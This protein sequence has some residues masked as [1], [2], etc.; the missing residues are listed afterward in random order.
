M[1][2]LPYFCAPTCIRCPRTRASLTAPLAKHERVPSQPQRLGYRA[3]PV[4]VPVVTP[5]ILKTPAE[6]A[7]ED[8]PGDKR[9]VAYIVPAADDDV[10]S[11]VLREYVRARLPDYMVPSAFVTL[12]GLPLTPNGKVDPNRLPVPNLTPATP[13]RAPRSVREQV[14]CELFAEVL[15][16]DRVGIDDDF[17]ALGGDS[18]VSI[19]M[20]SRARRAG[21]VISPRDVFEHK[22]VARLA[23]AAREVP[24]AMPE[25][26]DADAGVIPLTPIMRWLC[27][28]DAPIDSFAMGMVVQT[29]AGLS[30]NGLAGL[31]QALVDRHDLLRARLEGDGAGWALRVALVG[32]VAVSERIVRVDAAG[33]D[34]HN[35]P[36][37]IQTEAAT[38][39]AGLDPQDGVM[40]QAVWLDRGSARPG[41][42]LLVIH[43]LAV[44][45][46]SWRILL[47][48]LA[49][50]GAQLAAGQTPLL[51]PCGT[52]F[53]RWACL[54]AAQAQDPARVGELATWTAMLDGVDPLLGA[55]A[56]NPATDTSGGCREL[57]LASPT[58]TKP[59]LTSTPAAFNAG[60][61]D[62][63]LC[64]LALAVTSWR[65]HCR[66]DDGT[67]CVLVDLEGHGHQG[68]WSPVWTCPAPSAG[69]PSPSRCVWISAGSTWTRRWPVARRPGRRSS[70]S[71]SSYAP[72]P[73]MVWASGC[74]ATSILRRHRCW[75]G[76][77][78]H[79][80]RST[81]RA[82]SPPPTPPTGRS[83]PT[84]DRCWDSATT[85]YPRP[86]HWRSTPG[87]WID[88][89]GR[90]CTSAGDGRRS[91]CPRTR[92][93]TWP[94][95]GSRPWTR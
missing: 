28:H 15:G 43:H 23:A 60:V 45:G 10:R 7:R 41:R 3:P 89:S 18:I 57:K 19:Q 65:R 86:T 37:V 87:R 4:G 2:M 54:L 69:S 16:L 81:T 44:D 34:G 26:V 79:R 61:D 76:W 93:V 85:R 13:S 64:A 66:L 70:G 49:T 56:L 92:S 27:E 90:S 32:S 5:L 84:P 75:P 36:G 14:L 11:D 20:I 12:D 72:C 30:L 21:V 91:C 8:R 25:A 40:L 82:A 62:V 48:D 78:A 95:A 63:L 47:E 33:L 17:F 59:L 71:R 50:G 9:L 73:I 46:V 88:Q 39:I 31:V 77:P 1:V 42:L 29:P 67:G 94:R 52:S 22:T 38:A 58:Q 51:E 35:L 53:R 55:Q 80:S 24:G 68:R 83:P 74:C 6:I